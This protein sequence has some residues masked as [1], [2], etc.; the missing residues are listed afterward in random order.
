MQTLK[1]GGRFSKEFKR[2]CRVTLW[3]LPAGKSSETEWICLL[4]R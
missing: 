4:P 3:S 1:D 2:E